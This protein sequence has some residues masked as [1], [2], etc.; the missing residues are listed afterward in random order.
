MKKLE[1]GRLKFCFASEKI[2]K[3]QTLLCESLPTTPPPVRGQTE[4]SGRQG[5]QGEVW[6]LTSPTVLLKLSRDGK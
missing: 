4:E 5:R 2:E 6:H 1:L 3:K